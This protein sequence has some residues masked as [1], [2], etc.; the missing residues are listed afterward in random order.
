[1]AIDTHESK[2]YGLVVMLA[3]A[4]ARAVAVCPKHGRASMRSR[5]G[6]AFKLV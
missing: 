1:M 2:L 6:R 5:F 4:F 3:P